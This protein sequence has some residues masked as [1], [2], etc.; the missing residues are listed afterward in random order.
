M[1]VIFLDLDGVLT[2]Y[3]TRYKKFDEECVD[4]LNHILQTT[5]ALIVITS[6]MRV[7]NGFDKVV[8]LC[9]FGIMH[10]CWKDDSF[11]MPHI[12]MKAERIIDLAPIIPCYNQLNEPIFAVNRGKE[13][14]Q[15]L[16]GRDDIDR[17][18]VIDDDDNFV[19]EHVN[20]LI[21]VDPMTGLTEN[22]C[23]KAIN[24]LS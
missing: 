6:S 24:L 23:F 14:T 7:M 22:D 21:K 9:K 13:I 2:N 16:D 19:Q 12:L 11:Q 8:E 5:G 15:W 3:R 1:K 4:C 20:Y 18:V 17:Y 10:E